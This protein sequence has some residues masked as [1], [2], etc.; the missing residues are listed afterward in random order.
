MRYAY[1]IEKDDQVRVVG[2]GCCRTYMGIPGDQALAA[3]MRERKAS[4]RAAARE[5][6]KI[7]RE[8]LADEAFE[9]D[10]A[11]YEFLRSRVR[12]D[13][14]PEWVRD[15]RLDDFARRVRTDPLLIL[16]PAQLRFVRTLIERE[17]AREAKWRE[18]EANKCPE[19]HA[20]DESI[21]GVTITIDTLTRSHGNFGP[22]VSVTGTSASGHRWWFRTGAHSRAGIQL[23]SCATGDSITI[24][25]GTV[26]GQGDD[27]AITFLTRVSLSPSAA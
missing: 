14:R 3:R 4:E 13:G 6:E 27:R 11:L 25:R 8:R 21:S 18:R 23:E 10:R 22:T 26:T 17:E 24:E 7:E 19:L 2:T 20:R 1:R 5:K 9:R 12:A 15:T 16:T